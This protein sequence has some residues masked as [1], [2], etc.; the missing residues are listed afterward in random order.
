MLK[1]GAKTFSQLSQGTDVWYGKSGC[2][3]SISCKNAQNWRCLSPRGQMKFT[4][5]TTGAITRDK[6]RLFPAQRL[7][8]NHTMKEH[9][10]EV[11]GIFSSCKY[12]QTKRFTVPHM[13]LPPSA[14]MHFAFFHW[15]L[16]CE[17]NCSTSLKMC[18]P[19]VLPCILFTE[20]NS[21]VTSRTE[22]IPRKTATSVKCRLHL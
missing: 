7:L 2:S 1:N 4:V 9:R 19:V 15:R 20:A 12:L 3:A 8:V 16:Y 13:R 14:K 10:F 6:S 22:P 17:R 5:K 11:T 18:T 21:S